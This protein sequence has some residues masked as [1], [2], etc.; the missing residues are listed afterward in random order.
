[1]QITTHHTPFTRHVFIVLLFLV[2]FLERTIFD[3]G[4]NIELVT[5]VMILSAYY[6]GAKQSVWLTLSIMVL[7]DLILGNSSIFIFTWTGFLIPAIFADASFSWI[8]RSTNYKVVP[9][10]SLSL[11]SNLFFFL[12]TN[13]GVW[14]LTGMYS[15]T[16]LGLFQS[17]INGLPF[18]KNQIVSSLI[19]IPLGFFV[20]GYAEKILKKKIMSRLRFTRSAVN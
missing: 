20:V 7:S 1:M 18:L 12:W 15:K 11:F 16:L 10:L 19:F 6:F 5:A 14:L 2:A 4:P 3:L 17:Y 13:F 8:K 9:S